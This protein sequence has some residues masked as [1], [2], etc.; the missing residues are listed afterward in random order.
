MGR[1]MSPDPSGLYFA[2][3][4]RPQSF[5]L[6]NYVQN[7]P[8]INIDPTGLECVWDDGSYDSNTDPTTGNSSVDKHGNHTGC[9]KQGGTWLDH[10]VFTDNKMPD[11]SSQSNNGLADM[12]KPTVTVDTSPNPWIDGVAGA[13]PLAIPK[14]ADPSLALATAVAKLTAGFPTICSLGVYGEVGVGKLSVG[15]SYDAKAGGTRYAGGN[16]ASLA[17]F[18]ATV[19]KD[20]KGSY[21]GEVEARDPDTGVGGGVS[22]D[23][24]GTVS[25]SLSEQGG[26]VTAGVTAT[27]GSIGDAKCRMP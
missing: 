19:Q 20:S 15:G 2:T 23:N 10:S 1:F 3:L 5:N 7:N 13:I 26:P 11:W 9:S 27:L 12:V 6:Y 24:K 22:V 16:L 17:P 21:S 14:E 18:S 8:L 25:L 4:D